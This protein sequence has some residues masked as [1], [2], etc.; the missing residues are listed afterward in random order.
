MKL[1]EKDIA[2]LQRAL[3]LRKTFDCG[4]FPTGPQHSRFG[5]L[6]RAGLLAFVGHGRDYD[7]ELERDVAVYMI[8][9]A[10]ENALGVKPPEPSERL[11]LNPD[12][13]DVDGIT[14]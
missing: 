5:K 2:V 13:E 7:G 3:H 1:T 4:I 12:D 9:L 10:G 14:L 11:A 6:E 8:T